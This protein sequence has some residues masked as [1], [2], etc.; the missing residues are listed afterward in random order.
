MNSAYL[1]FADVVLIGHFSFVVFV[2]AGFFLVVSGGL[3]NWSWIRNSWFRSLHLLAIAIVVGQSW[4]NVV[5]PLTTL[6]MWLRGRAGDATY[7]GSFVQY[8]LHELL[9]YNA[10]M[11]VFVV[12]YS[13]FGLLVLASLFAFPPDFI[14]LKAVRNISEN[15]DRD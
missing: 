15:Q 3:L 8:W 1:F 12:I 2:I 14:R 10:P 9:Y 5:C 6:E 4:L 7:A 13:L 11:W